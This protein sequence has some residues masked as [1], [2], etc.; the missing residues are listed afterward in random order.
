MRNLLIQEITNKMINRRMCKSM[1]GGLSYLT[2]F[3]VSIMILSS[4]T[5]PDTISLES[6]LD[7][8]ISYETMTR[9]PNPYYTCHQASSY[10]R[11]S[12]SPDSANWFRNG[13]GYNG[14]N[15][16]RIDTIEGRVEKVMLDVNCPGVITRFWITSL[17]R[18]P[19]IRF[20][21]DGSSEPG[22]VIPSYDMMKFG[23]AGAGE[24]LIIPHTSYSENVGGST[25]FCP[26]PYAKACKITVEIPKDVDGNPRYYQINYRKYNKSAKIET[27]SE[28]VALRAKKKIEEVNNLLLNPDVRTE[29][30]IITKDSSRLNTGD[31][32]LI[33]L[34]DGKMAIHELTFEINVP[35]KNSFEQ[36]MRELILSIKFDAKEKIWVPIGDFSGGGMGSRPVSS[37]FLYSDGEGKIIKYG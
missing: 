21:F 29:G 36:C 3:I 20:Y 24:G 32:L 28:E 6:L 18:E 25:S 31:S 9:F 34:P 8:M 4:C 26:V 19:V 12:V 37:W 2:I 14:G 35:D 23:I 33:D 30:R 7:D 22:W 11:G 5:G 17:D 16:I 13:D 15:F 10:D 1:I 27:F